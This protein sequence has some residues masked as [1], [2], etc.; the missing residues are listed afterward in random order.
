MTIIDRI[1]GILGEERPARIATHQSPDWDALGFVFV[2]ERAIRQAGGCI[3]SGVRFLPVGQTDP[4]A[5]FVGDTGGEHDGVRTFDHHQ[6]VGAAGQTSATRLV[7]EAI[8]AANWTALDYLAPL[9]T[10]IN[11]C[12]LGQPNDSREIGIHALL[13][14]KKAQRWADAQILAWGREI[15]NDLADGLLSKAIAKRDLAANLLAVL[16]LPYPPYRRVAVLAPDAPRSCTQAAYEDGIDIVFYQ[17][18]VERDGV[19]RFLRGAVRSNEAAADV[20]LGKMVEHTIRRC[21]KVAPAIADEL[22]QWF[23]HPAGFMVGISEKATGG[24]TPMDVS[25]IDVAN[26]IM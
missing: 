4:A 22:R 8:Q 6:L 14:A 10:L 13:S 2:L 9:V 17:N 25:L 26:A 21:E 20:H 1:D 16:E 19:T 12:D 15:F 7:F 11:E 23:Q 24:E 3:A 18:E 5:D